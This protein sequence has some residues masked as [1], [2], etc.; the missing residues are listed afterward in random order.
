[1][2]VIAR[3]PYKDGLLLVSDSRV[4]NGRVPYRQKI[5]V[6]SEN[7][8]GAAEG[9]VDLVECLNKILTKDSAE[10]S[11]S[12]FGK[13]TADI[14]AL[15]KAEP[16]LKEFL[17]ERGFGAIIFGASRRDSGNVEPFLVDVQPALNVIAAGRV[18]K[19]EC[20]AN[21][22]DGS[23]RM[24]DSL[25]YNYRYNPNQASELEAEVIGY[26]LVKL[27]EANPAFGLYVG[28]PLEMCAIGSNSTNAFWMDHEVDGRDVTQERS[29]WDY[30]DDSL[31]VDDKRE[32]LI[33]SVAKL[34]NL[35]PEKLGALA[36]F[37]ENHAKEF[38]VLDAIAQSKRS[39][40]EMLL[41]MVAKDE[42]KA[43][44]VIRE[45]Y[46]KTTEKEGNPNKKQKAK[47]SD[48]GPI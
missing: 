9:S 39:E 47:G 11:N 15:M 32:N 28:D 25:V 40:F 23:Q 33:K 20:W 30:I 7:V 2:T 45:L 24:L 19:G 6:S 42:D 29:K 46:I 38:S 48:S 10:I 43:L 41:N 12:D 1:M 8:I 36:E 3:I 17:I 21:G 22:I 13:V 27:Q 4:T 5:I 34:A 14:E 44:S 16:N 18:Q 31:K 37:A 26:I 35:Y